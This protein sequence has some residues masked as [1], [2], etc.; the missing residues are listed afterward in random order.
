MCVFYTFFQNWI[1]KV[2][3]TLVARSSKVFA[4]FTSKCPWWWGDD[5]YA[6]SLCISHTW[7]ENFSTDLHTMGLLHFFPRFCA[8]LPSFDPKL[9][10]RGKKECNCSSTNLHVLYSITITTVNTLFSKSIFCSKINFWW[11]SNFFGAILNWNLE[12]WNEKKTF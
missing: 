11:K 2:L 3:I 12:F 5:T 10:R 7:S 6:S 8:K 1:N 4:I 9:Y